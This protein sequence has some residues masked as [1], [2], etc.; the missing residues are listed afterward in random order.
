MDNIEQLVESLAADTAKVKPAPHP[1][2]LAVKWMAAAAVYLAVSLAASG[3]RPDL[4]Q[5]LQQPWY[6]AELVM[7]LLVFVASAVSAALLSFPD[8]HQKQALAFSPVVLFALF[9]LLM[10]FAWNADSPPAPLPVHSWQCTLSILLVSLLPAAW[11]FYA[12]RKYASTHYRWAGSIALLSAFSVG[13]L[14][15]RLH[16]VNDSIYHV[17]LWHYLPMLGTGLF[18]LWLGKKLLKW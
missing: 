17:V 14:W 10:L 1:F 6:V 16:E 9:V 5:A 3:L 15:L 11:T 4:A 13:A 8:L 2:M 7:L 12:M 18:G